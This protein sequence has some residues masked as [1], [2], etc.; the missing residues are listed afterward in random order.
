MARSWSNRSDCRFRRIR[1]LPRAM[2]ALIGSLLL[3]LPSGRPLAA[4]LA[5]GDGVFR[6]DNTIRY[7]TAVRLSAPNGA[8]LSDPNADDG[9]RNFDPGVVSNRFDLL[10]QLDFAKRW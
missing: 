7:S 6:W 8:L 2:T 4:D 9:D 10:S 1:R 5:G 3:G